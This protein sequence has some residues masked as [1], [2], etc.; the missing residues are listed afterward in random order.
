M[1]KVALYIYSSSCCLLFNVLSV[2]AYMLLIFRFCEIFML[3]TYFHS[4][5]INKPY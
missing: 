1:G 3:S 2:M 4:N 5:V